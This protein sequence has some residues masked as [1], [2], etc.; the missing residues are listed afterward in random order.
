M[1]K[2]VKERERANKVAQQVRRAAALT[3]ELAVQPEKKTAAVCDQPPGLDEHAEHIEAPNMGAGGSHPP[4]LD[5]RA[6]YKFPSAS[7][8]QAEA[9]AS[10]EKNRVPAGQ[11]KFL[12]PREG[13]AVL[14]FD[15]PRRAPSTRPRGPNLTNGELQQ[16]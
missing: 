7:D 5:P 3:A 2:V 11:K 14:D 10:S 12:L 16:R 1:W 15:Q 13:F 4:R 8:N 6:T 9:S